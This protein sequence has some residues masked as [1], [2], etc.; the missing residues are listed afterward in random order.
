MQLGV[1]YD[2]VNNF[3]L[4]HQAMAPD[5]SKIDPNVDKEYAGEDTPLL[6]GT[7]ID[8]SNAI[9]LFLRWLLAVIALT[10]VLSVVSYKERPHGASDGLLPNITVAF[11]GNSMMFHNDLPRL[12]ETLSEQHMV[13]NSCFLGDSSL[14]RILEFGNGMY[15]KF[16][17]SKALNDD[18]YYDFGACT[19]KQLLLGDDEDLDRQV[20][21]NAGSS[22]AE[23]YLED[24]GTN[25]CLQNKSYYLYLKSRRRRPHWNYV[26]INDYTLNPGRASKRQEGL[27]VLQDVYAAW[28]LE[29]GATPVFFDTHAYWTPLYNL[30]AFVDVPTLTSVTYEGYL[31][32]ASLLSKLLPPLQKPRIAPVGIV[33]LTVWEE[34]RSLWYRLFQRFDQLHASPL[35]TLATAFVVFG[36]LFG[37]MPDMSVVLRHRNM[38]WLWSDARVLQQRKWPDPFPT[39]REAKYLYDVVD[40]VVSHGYFPKSLMLYKNGEAVKI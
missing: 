16:A 32:Y 2:D 3:Q 30:T 27:K 18:G 24:D 39:V 21:N 5:T 25:P 6:A 14:T 31:Q 22:K 8:R 1:N 35:G 7:A 19:V 4:L 11:V 37:R 15:K 13:Q 20:L 12:L 29:T 26:V 33:F 38:T 23:K 9:S 10:V 40:R 17:T 28:F 34:N 36:T